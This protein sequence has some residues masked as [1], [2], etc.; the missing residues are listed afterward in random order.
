MANID[1]KEREK[2]KGKERIN[3]MPTSLK[4]DP[5]LWEEVKIMSIRTKKNITEYFEEA[6]KEKLRRDYQTVMTERQRRIYELPHSEEVKPLDKKEASEFLE[7]LNEDIKN[8]KTKDLYI[9]PVTNNGGDLVL[10]LPRLRF[11]IDKNELVDY[12][13]SRGGEAGNLL[14][15]ILEKIPPDK[16]YNSPDRFSQDIVQ[17]INNDADLSILNEHFGKI[18]GC[19]LFN[20]YRGDKDIGL[21]EATEIEMRKK[22]ERI[23]PLLESH[24]DKD[25][26]LKEP[27]K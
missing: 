11:P 1:N 17:T 5:E 2:G 7:S 15:L 12:A 13:K 20:P 26:K 3:R 25:E 27:A 6:L 23:Q 21:R 9:Y 10:Y 4:V 18:I 16:I 22:K 19:T 8:A 14:L 24:Q